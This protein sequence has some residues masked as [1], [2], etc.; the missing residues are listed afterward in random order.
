MGGEGH[1]ENFACF[2]SLTFAAYLELIDDVVEKNNVVKETISS[3]KS[4]LLLVI[5][6]L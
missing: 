3:W 6:E 4:D 2:N 1:D 5:I